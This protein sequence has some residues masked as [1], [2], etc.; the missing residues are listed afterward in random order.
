[1][2]LLQ[3]LRNG[4][5]RWWDFGGRAARSEFWWFA[6][7]WVAAAFVVAKTVL[8]PPT[9]KETLLFAFLFRT[10]ICVPA[11]SAAARRAS[12]AS[13]DLSW[14][15]YGFAAILF[16]LGLFELVPMAPPE[17]N[18]AWMRPAGVTM[19]AGALLMLT[20]ILS[21]PSKPVANPNEVTQ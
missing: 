19:I 20:Y 18:V 7:L 5:R 1:M 21:R 14:V 11:L 17:A 16:G 10:L 6:P 12:D 3:A 9:N 13:F 2:T 8:P 4:I 15:G